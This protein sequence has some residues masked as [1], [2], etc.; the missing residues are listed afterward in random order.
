M[1]FEDLVKDQYY[2]RMD[3]GKR[4]YVLKH[5]SYTNDLYANYMSLTASSYNTGG[6]FRSTYDFLPATAEEIA[7]LDACIAANRWVPK[8]IDPTLKNYSVC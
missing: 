1:K 3:G 6:D 2:V 8:P 7:W 5:R 4:S